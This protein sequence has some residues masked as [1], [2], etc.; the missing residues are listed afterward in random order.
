VNYRWDHDRYSRPWFSY[1]TRY[2]YLPY[3]APSYVVRYSSYDYDGYGYGGG[4]STGYGPVACNRD[5]VGAVFGGAI[6][7]AIGASGNG[8]GGAIA[9]GAILGALLGG[10]L[11]QSID[12]NDQACIGQVLEY[13]P[14]DQPVYWSDNDSGVQYQVTPL[15][16]YQSGNGRYCREYQTYVMIDGRE[17]QAYGTACRQPDGAWSI[18]S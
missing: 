3:Y 7:A 6:G 13:G 9:G 10:T 15:R 1:R 14:N 18:G 17:E 16:T 11:G 5:V 12:M 4:Y 2:T 8:G